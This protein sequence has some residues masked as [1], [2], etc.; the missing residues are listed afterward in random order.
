MKRLTA[1]VISACLCCSLCLTSCSSVRI[2]HE[3]PSCEIT[4]SWWGKDDRNESTLEGLKIFGEQHEDISVRTEY[5]EYEGF[6]SRMN[7]EI[8]S[9]TEADVMQLNYDWLYEYSPDGT[10]FYDLSELSDHIDLSNFAKE[11]LQYGIIGGRLN[12]LPISLNAL[13]FAYNKTLYDSYGLKLPSTWEELFSAA[14]VMSKDGVYPLE[15]TKKSIWMCCCAYLEQTTG[16]SAL[17]N[18]FDLTDEDLKVMIDFCCRLLN[19]KVTPPGSD[20]D[21]SDISV[22]KAAGTVSW[23]SDIGYF[24]DEAET[25]GF[26]L[27]IG[28]YITADDYISYGWY[29]KPSSLYAIKKD[30]GD[31]EAAAEL[32]DFLL[33]SPDMAAVQGRT[34]GIPVSRSAAETLEARD[35]LGG[36]E[37]EAAQK[38][39]S[40]PQLKKMSPYIENADIIEVFNDACESVYYGKAT[41]EQAAS[42]AVSRMEK[43]MNA[44][45]K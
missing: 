12:A 21:R 45:E 30:C 28:D 41:S 5:G 7:C 37:F 4:Y 11:D 38:M 34:R 6:K 27:E 16:K 14:K 8:Y 40:D 33:N 25:G 3:E 39:N 44:P 23:I 2:I 36:T 35:M 42:D 31:P 32:M 29:I 22:L 9:D 43:I 26:E 20:Y 19:E 15:L 1:G 18:G 13:T 10:G 24:S 17:K